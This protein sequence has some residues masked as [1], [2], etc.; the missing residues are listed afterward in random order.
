M[1]APDTNTEKQKRR[2]RVPLMGMIG[3]VV[4]ALIG[5]GILTLWLGDGSADKAEPHA[6]PAVSDS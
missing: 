5:L 6:P 3:V 2:H 4:L 1:S